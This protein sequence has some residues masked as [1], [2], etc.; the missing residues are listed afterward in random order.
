M[1]IL[2][3]ACSA[4]KTKMKFDSEGKVKYLFDFI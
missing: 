2:K 1:Y 3:E 4:F